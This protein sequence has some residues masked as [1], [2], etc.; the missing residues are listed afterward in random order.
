VE[1]TGFVASAPEFKTLPNS[2]KDVMSFNLALRTGDSRQMGE[3]GKPE[4]KSLLIRVEKYL[5]EGEQEQLAPL[6]EKGK[7][8]TVDGFIAG[9]DK[10]ET[11]QGTKVNTLRLVAHNLQSYVKAAEGEQSNFKNSV[12]VSGRMT[13]DLKWVGKDETKLN[14]NLAYFSAKEGEQDPRFFLQ[15]SKF[16]KPE[17]KEAILP[18]LNPNTAVKVEGWLEAVEFTNKEGI[19]VST[20]NFVPKTIEKAEVKEQT[21]EGGAEQAK[22]AITVDRE[23]LKQQFP[24]AMQ[25]LV[26]E[27]INPDKLSDAQLNRIFNDKKGTDLTTENG[28][29]KT[30]QLQ[31][32]GD[33]YDIKS[34]PVKAKV[35]Q[36][37]A[38]AEM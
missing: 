1:L 12:T 24:D 19:K 22:P 37:D 7:L 3:D 31:K 15:M 10:Y 17:Q 13:K 35:E 26:Q 18:L 4:T 29:R 25:T 14:A 33:T 20:F 27:G 32:D 30:V 11:K 5:K 21:Q 38:G 9:Q 28:E 34:S 6:C 36:Q 2:G 16:M 23:A 8:V